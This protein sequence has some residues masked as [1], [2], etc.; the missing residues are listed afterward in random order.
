M[1][2]VKMKKAGAEGLS[3]RL[4]CDD[5]EEASATTHCCVNADAC[6]DQS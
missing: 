3:V 2:A 1:V 4:A 5:V 6:L